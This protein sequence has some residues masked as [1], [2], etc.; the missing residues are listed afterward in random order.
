[1]L[2]LPVS[3]ASMGL[4]VVDLLESGNLTALFIPYTLG[5][6]AAGIVTYFS[7]RWLSKLVQN[8]KL[9]KF[10]I[11]CFFLSLFVLFYFR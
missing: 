8:G 6:L 2:Y 11:Y 10:S 5:L 9:W 4:G 7:Y 1:M 3:V